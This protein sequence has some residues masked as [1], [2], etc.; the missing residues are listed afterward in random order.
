MNFGDIKRIHFVGVGGIGMSGL[1]EILTNFDVEIS[2]CDLK[3][4]PITQRL[5]RVGVP[6]EIGHDASHVDSAD[7]IVISSAVR[8]SSAPQA[9]LNT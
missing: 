7:M 8:G 2:G 3:S 1:A 5:L 4:S 6:V 9:C